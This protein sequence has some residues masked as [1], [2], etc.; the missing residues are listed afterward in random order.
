MVRVCVCM[1]MRAHAY[2]H[3]SERANISSASETIPIFV[4]V[5]IL[6]MF[7]TVQN[8]YLGYLVLVF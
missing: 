5:F 6:L 7:L 1:D 8:N 4:N 3:A 2:V